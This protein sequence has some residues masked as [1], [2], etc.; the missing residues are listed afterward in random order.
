M[1][2]TVSAIKPTDS[3][4]VAF[5]AA[6]AAESK[7]AIGTLILDVRTVTILA[8]Y[9]VITGGQS[10][11]QVG[12]IAD[13]IDEN[14]AK[15]GLKPRSIEGKT[16]GRWVL[17]DYEDIIVHILQDKERNYYKLEQFWNHALIVDRQEWYRDSDYEPTVET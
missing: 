1:T 13:A 3:R 7:K 6:N 9:F 11:A 12:A 5:L 4:N 16:E 14:L 10:T 17:L 2:E 8:D 15:L